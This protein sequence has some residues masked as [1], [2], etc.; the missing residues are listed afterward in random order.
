M[1]STLF[2]ALKVMAFLAVGLVTLLALLLAIENYRG[3]RAWDRCRAELAAQGEVLDWVALLPPPIPDAQNFYKTPLLAPLTDLGPDPA[4]QGLSW[5]PRDTNAV[6]KMQTL[7]SALDPAFRV[8][9]GSW[10]LGR[11]A[12]LAAFQTALRGETNTRHADLARLQA[13]PVGPPAADLLALLDLRTAE[14]G[15]LHAALDRPQARLGLP[16]P[17]ATLVETPHY[18]VLRNLG[19]A[20]T[21]RALASLA[22]G[23]AEGAARDVVDG[24][25]LARVI[26]SEPLLIATLVEFAILDSSLQPLWEGL[27]R[28]EW[29]EPHLAAFEAALARF[30][31]V[32]ATARSLRFERAW[33]IGLFESW[34][35]QPAAAGGAG[36]PAQEFV[37]RYFPSGWIAR[38]QAEIAR[39]FQDFL[40]PVLDTNRMVIDIPLGNRLETEAMKAL[41]G[42]QPYKVLARMLFPAVNKIAQR[43]AVAQTALHQARIAVALERHRLAHG[44]YPDALAALVPAFLP[45]V[46]VDVLNGQPY[47]Y[48]RNGADLISLRSVGLNLTDDGGLVAVTKRGTANTR[49]ATGDWVWQYTA[50]TNTATISTDD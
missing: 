3:K 11:P 16:G 37:P 24:L 21:L 35:R 40:I 23:E 8:S 43:A 2:K 5:G 25:R 50:V 32:A 22:A 6:K 7:F 31:L 28:H 27:A 15:E 17:A 1:K 12:D 33:S 29:R 4:T 13:T 9:G 39:M 49:V 48:S 36:G 30:D 42:W 44:Q 19:R 46:P 14:L 41:E 34:R 10:R 18:A 38:T 45:A 47:H 20:F 26:E